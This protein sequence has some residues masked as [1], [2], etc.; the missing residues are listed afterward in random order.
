MYVLSLIDDEV[1]KGI[2]RPYPNQYKLKVD[3][4]AANQEHLLLS[5]GEGILW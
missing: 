5:S 3:N 1:S 2:V 4:F